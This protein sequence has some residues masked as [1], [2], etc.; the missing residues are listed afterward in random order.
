MMAFTQWWLN[1]AAAEL[2]VLPD[3]LWMRT[4]MALGWA[5]VLAF[6]G[7]GLAARCRLGWRRLLAGG[8][9]LWALIPGVFS[10]TY[11]LGLAFHAP[12]ISAV[13]VCGVCLKSQLWPVSASLQRSQ[14]AGI[15]R[16][17]WAGAGVLMGYLLVFD[18]FA[19]MP[20]QLYAWG[21]RTQTVVL[22]LFLASLPWM[23]CGARCGRSAWLVPLA[24]L[25]FVLTRLPTGNV[26][27][28]L[29][30]PW[31][32]VGLQLLLLQAGWR[33]LRVS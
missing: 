1:L 27:D 4:G 28:A 3:P 33:R 19:Q 5:T 26:W 21:F 30:D 24:L 14:S 13:L 16:W 32:W 12:S 10:V 6:L 18:T 11:W 17:W 22:L 9:A 20:L 23:L 15:A 29:I 8:L 7:A 25:V 2:P 31:L